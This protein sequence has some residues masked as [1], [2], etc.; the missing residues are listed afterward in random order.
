MPGVTGVMAYLEEVDLIDPQALRRHALRR[1][2]HIGDKEKKYFVQENFGT[3]LPDIFGTFPETLVDLWVG[4]YIC[5][6]AS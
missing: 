4:C 3:P 6:S 2:I 1:K 5:P